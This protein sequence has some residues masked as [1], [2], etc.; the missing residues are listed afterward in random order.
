MGIP[1]YFRHITK[2]NPE[3]IIENIA[4][5]SVINN[6]YFDMN[7]LIHPCVRNVM[8]QFPD[9]VKIHNKIQNTAKYEDINYISDFEKQIYSEIEK[10]LDKLID[11]AKP[12][13]LI[14]LA[15]DGVAPR[16]KMEQQ[17]SRRYRSIKVNK[18]R[19]KILSKYKVEEV[20]F[21]TNCITPGTIFMLKLSNFLKT[22]IDKKYNQI[23]V[24]IY[25]DDCNNI[26][27]GEHKILQHMKEYARESVNCVY[28]LDADLIM[29][30]LVSGCKTYLL[31]ESVHFGKVDMDKLL[32]FDV[33]Q[34]SECLFMDIKLF[35]AHKKR[36]PHPS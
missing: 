7:C 12:N 25:L 16:A 24:P 11:F 27:E 33:E 20:Y 13:S 34:F 35:S 31:R 32:F 15:I 30:S 14:Y 2:N 36:S 4:D 8:K 1:K 21:D 29:L 9:Y 3:L 10:Y 6:L 17:R 22:Y 18:M 5:I 26:G 23:N 28:G 19:E